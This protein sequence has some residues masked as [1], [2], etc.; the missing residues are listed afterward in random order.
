MILN[1]TLPF[2]QCKKNCEK[3]CFF[4]GD[5]IANYTGPSIMLSCKKN[6][7]SFC[8]L[9]LKTNSIYYCCKIVLIAG[10]ATFVAGLCYAEFGAR[11]PRSGSAYS[12]VYK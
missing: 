7:S 11:V 1:L 12:N 10:L 9:Y 5:V 4:S 8:C 3:I 2:L 6:C